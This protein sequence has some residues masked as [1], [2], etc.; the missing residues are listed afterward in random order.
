MTRGILEACTQL[1]AR[2]YRRVGLAVTEWVDARS[3]HTYS[4]AMLKFQQAL[5]HRHRVP[6]L[7]FPE[8][9]LAHGAA[10]FCA[11]VKR[12]RPDVVISFDAYVV[13]WLR[14]R[15]RLRIPE[16]IGLVIHDWTECMKGLAGIY[17]RRPHVAAAAVDLVATQLMHNE[18]GAPEVPRQILVPPCWVEGPSIRNP[19]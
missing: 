2:G 13:D 14:N 4:G 10:I 7:L 17:H 18:R 8:N 15:L 5:A 3:D 1:T 12:Y 11:W 6:L 19:D 16:D 9:N